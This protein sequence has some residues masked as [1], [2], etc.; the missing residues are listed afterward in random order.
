MSD[1]A[2]SAM[3]MD[4][5]RCAAPTK[6]DGRGGNNQVQYISDSEYYLRHVILILGHEENSSTLHAMT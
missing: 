1:Y 4:Y 6:V 3:D 5:G 2:K